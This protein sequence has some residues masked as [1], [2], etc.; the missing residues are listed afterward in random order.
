MYKSLTTLTA[1]DLMTTSVVMVPEEMSLRGAA[2][3]FSEF[4]ISGAPVLNKQGKCVGV[5]SATDFVAFAEEGERSARRRHTTVSCAHSAW[6]VLDEE[7]LPHENVQEYMTA[8]PVTVHANCRIGELAQKMVDAHI[9]RVI[10]IDHDDKPIGIVTSTDIL[11]ALAN[12]QSEQL[13]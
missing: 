1:A 2:H 9:H 13:N 6:E 5:L 11:A 8:D 7:Q 10:V 4:H 3:L 12:A